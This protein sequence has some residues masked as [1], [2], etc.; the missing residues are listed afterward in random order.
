MGF[1]SDSSTP[2]TACKWKR[3]DRK[4]VERDGIDTPTRSGQGL[5]AESAEFTETESEEGE[6]VPLRHR[7]QHFAEEG[8]ADSASMQD[9]KKLLQGEAGVGATGARGVIVDH[10]GLI[11]TEHPLTR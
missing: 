4:S 9:W 5:V 7:I 8:G 11:R 1:H 3:S 2:V 10:A 6:G